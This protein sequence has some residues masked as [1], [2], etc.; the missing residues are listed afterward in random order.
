[1]GIKDELDG[2]NF[3]SRPFVS[4]LSALLM[5][6]FPMKLFPYFYPFYIAQ[7]NELTDNVPQYIFEIALN[8]EI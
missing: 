5:F 2:H 7:Q 1:M 3:S 4:K 8:L 6:L